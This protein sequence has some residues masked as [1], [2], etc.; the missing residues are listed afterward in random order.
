MAL[1]IGVILAN[2]LVRAL[3]YIGFIGFIIVF[4][5]KMFGFK[6]KDVP[7]IPE[8]PKV[9][10]MEGIELLEKMTKKEIR[11]RMSSIGLTVNGKLRL[12][13]FPIGYLIKETSLVAKK[14]GKK[15]KILKKSEENKE[16]PK[17]AGRPPQ[18]PKEEKKTYKLLQ[19]T[20]SKLN[21]FFLFNWFNQKYILIGKDMITETPD[22]LSIDPELG[23]NYFGNVFLLNRGEEQDILESLIWKNN[24]QNIIGE[25]SDYTRKLVYL[26]PQ[27]P[28]SVEKTSAEAMTE[29]EARRQRTRRYA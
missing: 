11:A 14:K 10:K 6:K 9:G 1:D 8:M 13:Y 29:E 28:T 25:L 7:G 26:L 16:E 17:P 23:L 19:Y 3:I 2:D 5:L 20:P 21:T 22:G 18:K 12:G 15:Y 24:Y 4:V 27:L